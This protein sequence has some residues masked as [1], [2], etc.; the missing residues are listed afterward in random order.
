MEKEDAVILMKEIMIVN[1]SLNTLLEKIRGYETDAEIA[2]LSTGVL[3][4]GMHIYKELMRPIIRQY[5]EIDPDGDR[6]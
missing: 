3:S 5:P 1:A 2:A 6:V 4:T